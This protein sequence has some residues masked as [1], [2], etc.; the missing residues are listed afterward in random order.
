MPTETPQPA[1][2]SAHA[3]RLITWTIA[4]LSGS[5]GVVLAV[6]TAVSAALG[7][8]FSASANLVALGC[9]AVVSLIVAGIGVLILEHRRAE[10][11]EQAIRNMRRAEE[12]QSI[13]VPKGLKVGQLQRWVWE[14]RTPDLLDEQS[15]KLL[16]EMI[17]HCIAGLNADT[18]FIIEHEKSAS[19]FGPFDGRRGRYRRYLKWIDAQAEVTRLRQSGMIE[20]VAEDT[21]GRFRWTPFGLAVIGKLGIR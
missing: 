17:E 18:R 3:K 7:R 15:S 19:T 8:P 9:S 13:N 5:V 1:K 10:E 14:A 11:A 6:W 12:R 2:L 16:S 20:P 4:L 21:P